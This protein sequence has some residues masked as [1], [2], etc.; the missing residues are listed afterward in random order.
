[1]KTHKEEIKTTQTVFPL[2]CAHLFEKSPSRGDAVRL[3]R[4]EV[5]STL[6]TFD[7]EIEDYSTERT[8]T[9]GVVVPIWTALLGP[10]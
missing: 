3:L 8:L 1:M 2:V 5:G 10:V 9:F 7:L 4:R 6:G